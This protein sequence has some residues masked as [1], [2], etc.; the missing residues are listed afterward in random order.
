MT[1]R[2]NDAHHLECFVIDM[3]QKERPGSPP[4]RSGLPGHRRA[5]RRRPLDGLCPGMTEASWLRS[6]LIA[7]QL[8]FIDDALDQ[9]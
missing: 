2:F 1:E 4:L 7:V 5:K 9:P 3:A 8:A 6:D